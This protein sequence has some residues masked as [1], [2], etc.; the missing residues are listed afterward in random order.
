MSDKEEFS[1][2][3]CPLDKLGYP[4]VSNIHQF[5][6]FTTRSCTFQQLSR[7]A[8]A[9]KNGEESSSGMLKCFESSKELLDG[10][11]KCN[12]IITLPELLAGLEDDK[13]V[14]NRWRHQLLRAGNTWKSEERNKKGKL[15]QYILQE[16]E[17]RAGAESK[18]QW[19]NQCH[20]REEGANVQWYNYSHERQEDDEAADQK[21]GGGFNIDQLCHEV[22]RQ[23]LNTVCKE[24]HNDTRGEGCGQGGDL[25]THKMIITALGRSKSEVALKD[26]KKGLLLLQKPN[27]DTIIFAEKCSPHHHR[28]HLFKV[29]DLDLNKL[30]H[31]V[32]EE[33]ELPPPAANTHTSDCSPRSSLSV[34]A[35]PKEADQF[36]VI[37]KRSML[38]TKTRRIRSRMRKQT[39]KRHTEWC[40]SSSSSDE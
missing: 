28:Q 30:M 37:S 4:K 22:I 34:S 39:E 16:R 10:G 14:N 3:V 11:Y 6:L 29:P 32:L 19:N 18:L 31:A 33:H 12:K 7:H 40:N 38:S 21:S 20:E 1:K 17:E 2:L 23:H 13:R 25:K 15:E 26:D 9:G 35:V 8:R 36:P 27:I 5:C 24:E